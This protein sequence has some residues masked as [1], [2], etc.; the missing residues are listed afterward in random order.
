MRCPLQAA[1]HLTAEGW[2]HAG[3][4]PESSLVARARAAQPRMSMSPKAAQEWSPQ[5]AGESVRLS[6][7]ASDM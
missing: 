4:E 5:A 1:W 2:G 7:R 6:R 3:D